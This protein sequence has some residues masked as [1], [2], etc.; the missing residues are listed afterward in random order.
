M[1]KRVTVIMDGANERMWSRRTNNGR[2]E[3]A[4]RVTVLNRMKGG[5]KSTAAK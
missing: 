4:D 3:D 1:D 5:K 2:Q